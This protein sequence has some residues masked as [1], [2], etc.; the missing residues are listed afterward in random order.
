MALHYTT[1][2]TTQLH[3]YTTRH[4][5]YNYNYKYN[6]NYTNYT[7]PQLH[8]HYT[9]TTTTAA[10]HH[11]TSSSCGWGDQV[12]T[13][14]IATTPKK[15][16]SSHLLVHQWIRSAIRDSQQPTSPFGVLILKLPPPPHAVLLVFL[17]NFDMFI[18]CT[19]IGLLAQEQKM[20]ETALADL[21][22]PE[23][24]VSVTTALPSWWRFLP[25]NLPLTSPIR[26]SLSEMLS[27]TIFDPRPRLKSKKQPKCMQIPSKCTYISD[28]GFYSFFWHNMQK[29]LYVRLRCGKRSKHAKKNQKIMQSLLR[30]MQR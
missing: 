14:T 11:T 13:A 8:L 17:D 30:W 6:Y 29:P 27:W 5:N 28:A 25:T 20:A 12:T 24:H 23:I 19:R 10:L 18:C 22:I 2:T 4:H 9:T 15:H 26:P 3:N 1:T 21:I 16:N 7:T